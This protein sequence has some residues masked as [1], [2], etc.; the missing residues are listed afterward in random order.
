MGFILSNLETGRKVHYELKSG[1][2]EIAF[3]RKDLEAMF[4]LNDLTA[5]SFKYVSRK[6][7]VISRL[8]G[9][10]YRL[11]DFSRN[12]TCVNGN[13]VKVS[14]LQDGDLIRIGPEN[15][16]SATALYFS[17]DGKSLASS[18]ASFDIPTQEYESNASC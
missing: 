4:S 17:E 3:G 2:G 5:P 11:V 13:R 6:H 1:K 16:N 18:V 14:E 8:F 12:G 15:M 9:G 10:V 7:F